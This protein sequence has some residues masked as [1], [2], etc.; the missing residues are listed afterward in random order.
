[1]NEL[2]AGFAQL[3]AATRD[4]TQLQ[5]AT[6]AGTHTILCRKYGRPHHPNQEECTRA[7]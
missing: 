1:M 5:V 2:H 7:N 3:H 4:G 6:R